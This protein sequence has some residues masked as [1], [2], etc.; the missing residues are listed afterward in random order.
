[1]GAD[2]AG[3]RVLVTGSTRGIGRAA[4]ELFLA[5]GAEVILHGR[6]EADAASAAASL[7][8]VWVAARESYRQVLEQVTLADVVAGDLPAGVAQLVELE[9]AWQSFSA[10]DEQPARAGEQLTDGAGPDGAAP[11]RTA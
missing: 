4:A 10:G 7:A 3:R 9:S 6:R 11:G 5:R 1:M 8:S 2:L